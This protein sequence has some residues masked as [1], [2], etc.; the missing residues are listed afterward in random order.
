MNKLFVLILL[1]FQNLTV[2]G[3]DVEEKIDQLMTALNRNGVFN[4]VVLVASH[5]E[6]I[7]KKAFGIAD[8]ELNVPLTV[9]SKFK[10][11]SLSKSFTALAILQLVQQ[12][13]I[14]LQG[15]IKDYIP[16]YSEPSGDSI[17]IHQLLT[18]SSGIK[19]NLDAKEEEIKQCLHH[20]LRD[21]VGYAEHSDLISKPGVKFSYSNFGYNILAYIIQQVSGKLFEIYLKENIFDRAGMKNTCQYNNIILEKD[22]ARG[23]EYKLLYGFQN[24]AFV[25]ASFT[26]GS[27][28]L[29][30]NAEDLYLFNK[31]L[32]SEM[33]LNQN[34]KNA[35]F[36]AYQPG[37]YG[38][39]WFISRMKIPGRTDSLT[40]ADHSGS[41][42]GF[43]TYM[44]RILTDSSI[45]VVL[46]N[47]RAD[48][49]VDPAFAPEIGKKIIDVLY[50]IEIEIPKESIAKHIALI[51]G[52]KGTDSA[53]AEYYRIV[54]NEPDKFNMEEQEL[55]KLG[56]ELYFRFNM[57]D[58]ATQIFRLNMLQ[59][60]ESYNTYDSYAYAL[61][62][63][64]DYRNSIE[65]YKK[66]LDVLNR[67]PES[68]TFTSVKKDAAKALEYIKE[69]EEKLK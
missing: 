16:D 58:E 20:E 30:S 7:Y 62:Q 57:P 22:L 28:G 17:T 68:N 67:Y 9:D 56:I 6:I 39:G 51:L 42:D 34:Y 65:S 29:I 31:I 44:A 40:I 55:N 43:G 19:S 33:L 14:N 53:I 37:I 36:K 26:V 59:F 32:Y 48:T 38:Y 5:D 61:M 18:H 4:G 52:T 54:K 1:L 2:Y 10:I 27:G 12:G 41:I 24:P 50:G 60:P 47:Q 13:K 66:G 3:Q 64:G 35:V 11:A 46:K 25:D 69:M 49:Y 15:T 23:Y 21:L 45:V 8:R 63:K